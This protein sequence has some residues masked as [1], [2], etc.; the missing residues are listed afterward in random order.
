MKRP[1]E[2]YLTEQRN[3]QSRRLDS[4]PLASLLK[5][6]CRE[7][8]SAVRAV[9]LESKTLQRAVEY[10]VEALSRQG[11]LILIGAGTSGRLAVME[12]AECPPTFDSPA[13]MVQ[14]IM[15]GG[16]SAL[17]RSKE[18]AE[19]AP[20]AGRRDLQRRRLTSLDV[21]LGIT[22]SGSTPYVI[23]ALHY[24]RS[25]K[26]GTILL[27]C[28]DRKFVP[29]GS[30]DIVIAVCTGPEIVTGS[31][32]L[33][34]GTATKVVLNAITTA[35]MIRLGK[36]YDNLMVDVQVRSA[37][38]HDRAI[39]IVRTLTGVSA[40]RARDALQ[41]AGGNS[42]LAVVMIRKHVD[43]ATAH[44]LLKRANGKLRRVIG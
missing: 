28:N 15:C 43:H 16:R 41:N 23:G 18:G 2:K 9:C 37:K 33:K 20:T 44:R 10:I 39:R 40:A 29:R 36:V 3:P 13:K 1:F 6:I 21:V 8:A 5:L 42:K 31:T 35:A 14:G 27:T 24:A 32:R 12:A 26:A 38:L 34:A 7:N 25:L 11:R 22:A 4:L 30:A 19:D 17:I